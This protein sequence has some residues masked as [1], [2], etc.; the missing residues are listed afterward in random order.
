MRIVKRDH[1]VITVRKLTVFPALY[2]ILG[3]QAYNQ[4]VPCTIS[5]VD[6][7]GGGGGTQ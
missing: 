3:L 2:R 5:E 6:P 4:R 1:D 7:G